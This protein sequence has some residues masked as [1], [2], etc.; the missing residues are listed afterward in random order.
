MIALAQTLSGT[1]KLSHILDKGGGLTLKP[2]QSQQLQGFEV[3]AE[4]KTE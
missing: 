1:Q 2:K 4:V 3:K